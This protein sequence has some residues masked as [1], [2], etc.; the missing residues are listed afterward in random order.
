MPAAKPLE[1][2]R[3]AVAAT[4][5][6][7]ARVAAD[8]GQARPARDAVRQEPSKA[9]VAKRSRQRSRGVERGR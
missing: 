5:T 4:G 7:R 3:R 2:R 6:P 1:S 8:V 9:K